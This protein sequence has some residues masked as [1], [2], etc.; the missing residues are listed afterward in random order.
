MIVELPTS[1]STVRRFDSTAFSSSKPE[2]MARIKRHS[3]KV[4]TSRQAT[5]SIAGTV[6]T[7][8]R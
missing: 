6:C 4:K 7:S 3:G 1:V 2:Q 5:N 8:N